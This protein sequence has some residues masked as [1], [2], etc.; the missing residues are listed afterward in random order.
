MAART[1]AP[2]LRFLTIALT[3]FVARY[4]VQIDRNLNSQQRALLDTLLAA[5]NSLMAALPEVPPTE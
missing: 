2:T 4:R 3:K 1:Y 5:A